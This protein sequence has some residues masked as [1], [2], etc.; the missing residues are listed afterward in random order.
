MFKMLKEIPT[1]VL[2]A[3]FALSS[4]AGACMFLFPEVII[5][6]VAFS[7]IIAS[8]IRIFQYISDGK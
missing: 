3:I 4:I 1:S 7:V 8:V 6:F 2:I 5:A